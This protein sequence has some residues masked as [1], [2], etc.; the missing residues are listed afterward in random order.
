MAHTLK[1]GV[2]AEGVETQEQLAF[3]RD[4]QCDE[5][6]GY[7]I[8]RPVSADLLHAQI[9][10]R[11]SIHTA[12]RRLSVVTGRQRGRLSLLR[13]QLTTARQEDGLD[14]K[15]PSGHHR[16]GTRVPRYSGHV[17]ACG[18]HLVLGSRGRSVPS[19]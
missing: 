15:P 17:C 12:N 13:L 16:Q 10:R 2:L 8:G 19:R 4:S 14:S 5:A 1:L 11:S 6:Q 18:V 7:L 3:L 9:A